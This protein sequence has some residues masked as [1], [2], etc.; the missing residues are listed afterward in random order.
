MAINRY[1][2]VQKLKSNNLYGTFKDHILI[3][4]NIDNGIISYKEYVTLSN[5]RLDIIAGREYGDSQYW[6]VIAAA[7]KIGWGL[8]IPEGVQLIIP[9][10]SQVFTILYS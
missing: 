4:N 7:S 8:Q 5:D 9:N 1:Q 3:R 6:W 2:T 10:I